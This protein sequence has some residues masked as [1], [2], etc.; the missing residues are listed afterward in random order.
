MLYVHARA[1]RGLP[2]HSCELYLYT[3]KR[4][5][6]WEMQLTQDV[7]ILHSS[8][9]A[10]DNGIP[11]SRNHG[12]WDRCDYVKSIGPPSLNIHSTLQMRS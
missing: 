12:L 5:G 1:F 9:E 2:Y 7:Q 8:S 11:D 4:H 10:Q 3:R 6:A